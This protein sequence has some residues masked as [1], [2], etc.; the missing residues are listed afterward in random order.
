M[1]RA[2][3]AAVLALA[4]AVLGGPALGCGGGGGWHPWPGVLVYAVTDAGDLIAFRSADPGDV[5]SSVTVSG[6]QPGEALVAIDV[7][8]SNGSL[9][10]VGDSARLYTIDTTSGVATAVSPGPFA[11][12]AGTEFS[13]DFHPVSDLLRLVSDADVNLRIDPDTG[14]LADTDTSLSYDLADPASG[15]DPNVVALAHTNSF[16]GAAETTAFALDTDADAFVRLGGL[17]GVPSPD[18]GV[19]FT[20]GWLMLNAE[21][22]AG[23]DA[24]RVDGEDRAYAVVGTP[25]SSASLLLRIEIAT[26]EPLF[27]GEIGSG[28]R[29][30][31]IAVVP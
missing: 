12:L 18:G 14:L 9:Y 28:D 2:S 27:L 24:V 22:P 21:G 19:L 30:T 15:E 31:A 26:G 16:D 4:V 10:G 13:L 3:H 20:V 25:G 1:K 29:V 6:L 7:R 23:L 11:A 5:L 8:P 17:D